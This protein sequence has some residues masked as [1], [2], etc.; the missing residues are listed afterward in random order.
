MR[1]VVGWRLP[2]GL[3]V[4]A[5]LSLGSDILLVRFGRTGFYYHDL[6]IVWDG[7]WRVLNGQIPN[8]HFASPHGFTAIY[9]QAL[10]FG[11]FGVSYDTYLL[12][13]VLL[14]TAAVFTAWHVLRK[15]GLIEALVGSLITSMW[16]FL[17]AA[18]PYVD[19]IAFF[20]AL[21]ALA[22]IFRGAQLEGPGSVSLILGGMAMG[23]SVLTKQNIGA[24]ATVGVSS[25]LF[26]APVEKNLR[27]G[28]LF[29]ASEI[30]TVMGFVISIALRGGLGDLI[31][32]SVVLPSSDRA[33]ALGSQ[34][35]N[36]V[37]N[38]L[39]LGA[40]TEIDMAAWGREA[41]GVG[42]VGLVLARFFSNRRSLEGVSALV[43]LVLSIVS[44]GA[45]A[46]S[47]NEWPLY[48]AYLGLIAPAVGIAFV[49]GRRSRAAFL[50]VLSLWLVGLGY[51]VS[52]TR[53]VMDIP[54]H[55]ATYPVQWP[56]LRGL[57]MEQDEQ[58]SLDLLL[59][60]ITRTVP[61]EDPIL[62]A[63]YDTIIYSL[64]GRPSTHPL[65]FPMPGWVDSDADGGRSDARLLAVLE[66]SPSLWV[67]TRRDSLGDFLPASTEYFRRNFRIVAD[68][69]DLYDVY[70]RTNQL[71]W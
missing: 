8:V 13:G 48:G 14:N 40:P 51:H 3:V 39:R 10:L 64:T 59:R 47:H 57:T 55:K 33:I 69:G 41:L 4:P 1:F 2:A 70:R 15:V 18:A 54:V 58:E 66:A 62:V 12:H 43:A 35:A 37:A 17:P 31:H 46:T 60:Y 38:A 68:V 34:L 67:I 7:A 20:W 25:L 45:R 30:A 36:R 52:R 16:F 56:A 42:L 29:L 71:A 11:I 50:S 6:S 19:N 27:K 61:S 22:L 23:L 32:Y 24:L 65:L 53:V 9:Q 5:V 26:L 44:I 21:V 28:A 49:P 63:G